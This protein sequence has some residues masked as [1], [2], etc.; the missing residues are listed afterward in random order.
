MRGP[1]SDSNR[2]SLGFQEE[3]R[4]FRRLWIWVFVLSCVALYAPSQT[5]NGLITGSIT[6]ATGA[7]VPGAQVKVINQGTAQERTAVSDASGLYVVPQLAPG[8]YTVTT[9]KDG[10][11][12]VKQNN[13]QILVNQSLT[14]DV[15]LSVA[16][17]AQ[18]VEVTEA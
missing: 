6:D 1:Q 13:I 7:V 15:K 8:V 10:F 16:S 17:V 14:I 12:T 11:G 4:M 18:T 5:T 3:T 9:A 2:N